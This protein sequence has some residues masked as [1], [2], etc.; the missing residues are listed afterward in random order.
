MALRSWCTRAGN[1]HAALRSN[2]VL[3]AM[4]QASVVGG[5]PRSRRGTQTVI[6]P[7]LTS[8]SDPKR[9]PTRLAEKQDQ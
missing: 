3:A 7:S 6:H 2:R 4:I 1:D 9:A 5:V 8:E